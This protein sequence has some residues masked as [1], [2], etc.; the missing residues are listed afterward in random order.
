MRIK[1]LLALCLLSSSV[2][3]AQ[4][5]PVLLFSDLTWG[6]NSGWEGSSTKGAAVTVWGEHF[7]TT[8]GSSYVTVN[9]AQVNPGDYAEWDAIGPA[10]GLERITF[11]LNSSMAAGAGTISVTVNGVTSNT[12]PF[13]IAAGT[14]YFI[15]T[16]GSNG[17]NGLYSTQGSGSNGPFKD[18]Y[19]FNPGQDSYH[20]AGNRNP[21]GDGQYIVYVRGGTYTTLDTSSGVDAFIALRGPY[22]GPTKQKALIG[23]PGETPIL[24]NTNAGHGTMWE[25]QYSPYGRC[26]YFTLAKLTPQNGYLFMGMWGDYNRAVG[27][28][29]ATMNTDIQ[30]G[31]I[32]PSNAQYASLYGNFFDSGGA[33][34]MKHDIYVKSYAPFVTG[35]KDVN[36]I[37]IAWNEDSN[38]HRVPASTG[39]GASFFISRDGTA[40]SANPQMYTRNVNIHDNYFHDG[41]EA[42][43]YIGDGVPIND[44]YI[45]NNV[46]GPGG[47]GPNGPLFFYNGTTNVYFYNNTVFQAGTTS[48]QL[49]HTE[50][51]TWV[52]AS[53]AV[54][55]ANNIFY[56]LSGEPFFYV[57]TGGG[58]TLTSDH[59][60]FYNGAT[61]ASTSG[62]TITNALNA[63]PGFVNAAGDNFHL[64]SSSSPADGGGVAESKVA[65]D[66]D[67]LIR[68]NPP[69]MGAFEFAAGTQS[70]LNPPTGLTATVN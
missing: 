18:I 51:Q 34:D 45:W 25:A 48:V 68:P 69:S 10:R 20:S 26:D 62:M 22:G 57:Y 46:F 14:I 39:T 40:A 19:M 67:G 21:S 31:T 52:G 12:L 5:A 4:N 59:D 58:A 9:G 33:S 64:S 38:P 6:P 2:V 13:T 65:T 27:N 41:N 32:M 37:D 50:T 56:T 29:L 44:V 36:N 8:R 61:P 42:Y 15:S 16:S 49:L 55:S 66:Y 1:C 24:D 11:W 28:H 70:S 54:Y 47:T 35:D 17:N 23:Y 3:F 30:A 60:L 63:N 43:I 53:S 7:G